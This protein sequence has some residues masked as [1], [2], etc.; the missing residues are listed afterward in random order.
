MLLF[1]LCSASCTYIR[2]CAPLVHPYASPPFL[3]AVFTAYH[4]MYFQ[5]LNSSL[6]CTN[7]QGK[8]QGIYIRFRCPRFIFQFLDK[9][10]LR[11]KSISLIFST[12]FAANLKLLTPYAAPKQPSVLC[13]IQ[14]KY[15]TRCFML[16]SCSQAY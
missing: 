4:L 9:L 1:S 12:P 7:Y 13:I 10:S 6:D 15:I 5:E 16:K 8:N 11:H 2:L 14:S 3:L